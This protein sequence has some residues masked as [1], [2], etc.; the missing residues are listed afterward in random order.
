ML[1][2]NLPVFRFRPAACAARARRVRRAY[3]LIA[4]IWISKRMLSGMPG[5]P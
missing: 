5:R 4:S 1:T 3:C 2:M